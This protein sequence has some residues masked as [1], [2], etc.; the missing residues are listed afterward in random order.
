[1]EKKIG[2]LV[3]LPEEERSQ[4]TDGI[5]PAFWDFTGQCFPC[6]FVYVRTLIRRKILRSKDV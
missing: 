3:E 5:W 6:H 1:M 4:D 2:E